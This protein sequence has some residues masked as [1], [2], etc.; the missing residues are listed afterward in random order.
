M[1]D[2]KLYTFPHKWLFKEIST[3]MEVMNKYIIEVHMIDY[4]SISKMSKW[5]LKVY[6]QLG[7]GKGYRILSLLYFHILALFAFFLINIS[8]IK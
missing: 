1:L 4:N 7:G 3:S 5:Y 8:F 6:K 2:Q